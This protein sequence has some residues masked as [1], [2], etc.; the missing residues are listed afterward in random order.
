MTKKLPKPQAILFDWDNTLVDTWPLIH[1]AL[2]ATLKAMGQPEWPLAQVRAVVKHS[3]RDSFPE[4]FGDRWEEAG[5]IYQESYRQKNLTHLEP[6]PGAKEMLASIPRPGI[7][8]AVVSNKQGPTLRQEIPA[9]GWQNYFDTAVGATD[10]ARDKPHAE[11]ALFALRDSGIAAGPHIWFIGDT[12]ADLGCA[13]A[14]GATAILYGDHDT[15]GI[16]LNGDKFD[17]HI[18]HLDELRELIR[19]NYAA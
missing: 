16:A 3:M 19:V 8:T 9:L 14:I 13:A 1:A 11:P 12:N 15:D 10:A 4:M 5:R 17:A 7:F 2:N 18:Q 6:L